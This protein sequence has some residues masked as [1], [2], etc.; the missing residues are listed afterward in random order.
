[1]KFFDFKINAYIFFIPALIIAPWAN[2]A[3]R[4]G[5]T[6]ILILAFITP[7][8][9]TISNFDKKIYFDKQGKSYL[10]FALSSLIV[11]FF[12]HYFI[13]GFD[14]S[15]GG[16]LNFLH[17]YGILIILCF[18][19]LQVLLINKNK[20]K[21]L[22]Q[23]A[24]YF[25]VIGLINIFSYTIV[26]VFN[27]SRSFE[28]MQHFD[29]YDGASGRPLG[30]TGNAAVNSTMLVIAYLLMVRGS[31][32]LNTKLSYAW[33]ICC[34]LG[35]IIQKSG[36]GAASLAI[37]F[38][39]HFST[40]SIGRKKLAYILIPILFSLMS[41]FEFEA[42]RRASPDYIYHIYTWF[43]KNTYIYIS[44]DKSLMDVFFGLANPLGKEVSEGVQLSTDFGTLYMINQ[45]G[46]IFFISVSLLLFRIAFR[47]KE[48]ID[49]VIIFIVLATGLH[50]QIIFF[51]SS[52]IL[53]SMYIVVALS[54]P[55]YA[56][57][58]SH[59]RFQV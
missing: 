51:L 18:F 53:F 24:L 28:L 38:L 10:I 48:K 5:Y 9:V 14:T 41:F 12:Y 56:K 34:T 57:N 20:E 25:F 7:V 15:N 1:M 46:L 58:T 32:I 49:K 22:Y 23:F 52:S 30:I 3:T 44:L 35:V 33:L 11:S 42:V 13:F 47:S 21:I 16:Y 39:Y 27:L 29:Y 50:Y 37:A 36:S 17:F 2:I 40:L 31:A 19:W 6:Y 43:E 55:I 4:H 8:F 26:D 45:V 59:L 54:S